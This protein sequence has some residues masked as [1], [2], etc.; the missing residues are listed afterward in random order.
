MV[1]CFATRACCVAGLALSLLAVSS[2]PLT[3]QTFYKWTDDRGVVH[4]ADSPPP[5]TKVEERVLS[6]P[7][8]VTLPADAQ[9]DAPA[10]SPEVGKATDGTGAKATGAS[11]GGAGPGGTGPAKVVMLS[12]R[13]PRTGPSNLHLSGQVKNVGGTDA[14][15]VGVSV[16]AVDAT[17]G[18]QCLH[19][20]IA[21]DPSTLE[22]G[23]TGSFDFDLDDPCLF[24]EAKVNL[25]P[26][27][28]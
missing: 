23:A 5:R 10:V 22:P 17:Q 13:K 21:V 7:P 24:G 16:V 14:Q 4:L 18:T 8:V 25:R 6:V 2:G 9:A 27:W 15:G 28:D 11:D 1:E 12:S 20:D 19:Q 26:V 3:A